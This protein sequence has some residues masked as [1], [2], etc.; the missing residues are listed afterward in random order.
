MQFPRLIEPLVDKLRGE[1]K[2]IRY[3]F[4]TLPKEWA[5]YGWYRLTGRSWIDFYSRRLDGMVVDHLDVPPPSSY[6]AEGKQH[7]DFLLRNGLTP[8]HQFLDYG[9]GVFRLGRFAIPYLKPGHY[10]GM[11]I[12]E[13][14]IEKGRRLLEKEGIAR[15]SFEAIITRD[16]LL[17]ELG[18]RRF[19]YV[20]AKSVFTHMPDEDIK[21]MLTALKDHLT[22]DGAYYFTFTPSEAPKRLKIKDFFHPPEYM[23]ALVESCGYSFKI[24]PDWPLETFGDLMARVKPKRI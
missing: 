19:D 3:R 21:T 24:C 16:C 18:P 11:E 1:H 20:W 14:R 2:S 10:V 23:R 4:G 8:D 5:V 9:C 6:L 17:N 7:F 15:N 22:P 13:L 12:S